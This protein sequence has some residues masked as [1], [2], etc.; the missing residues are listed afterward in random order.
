MPFFGRSRRREALTSGMIELVLIALLILANGVF[1]TAEMALV[2]SNRGRLARLDAEG[3]SGARKAVELAEA[4]NR[5]L[6]TV[7]VGITL[8]GVLSGAFGGA[9]LAGPLS[10]ALAQLAWLEPYAYTVAL[11]AV[12]GAIT[13]FTLV[14]GELVPKRLALGAPERLAAR[15]A[16]LMSAISR[17]AAP[18]VWLLSVSTQGVLRLVGAGADP[19][20]EV[21]EDDIHLLVEEGLKQGTVE[22][23]EREIIQRAFWLGERRL[24]AILTP[25]PEIVWLDLDAGLE[26]LAK[27][28]EERPHARYLVSRGEVDK[29]AGFVTAQDLIKELLAGRE[30]KLAD[31]LKEPLF[32]PETMPT[33][34]LL[35]RFKSGGVHFA[36]ALDEYGGVEGIV[37]LHDLLEELV[38]DIKKP[39]EDSRPEVE[40]LSDDAYSV[41]GLFE[42]DL[43][44]ERLGS[45][46]IAKVADGENG[47]GPAGMSAVSVH[48][49]GGLV[50]MQLG[51]IPRT[52][53]S[54]ELGGYRFEVSEVDGL[55][56][57]R[58]EVTKIQKSERRL[59]L[60]KRRAGFG[61]GRRT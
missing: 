59:S 34:T 51:E 31:H 55:R 4:P 50:A 26:G 7:Q 2:S 42:L 33:L 9:A 11:V 47:A 39:G 22:P 29:V 23:S 13:F 28:I 56:T 46:A 17:V 24:N 35:Q 18:I 10:E 19:S 1:A 27:L 3:N 54:I 52:G 30:P 25:R 37:T 36:V 8:I 14:F 20:N 21:D 53:D 6:S 48:T 58:V 57:S 44:A 43:L 38:G 60:E 41:D 49:V 15:L 16:P 45:A 40:E 61:G 5:F 12:V 32:V